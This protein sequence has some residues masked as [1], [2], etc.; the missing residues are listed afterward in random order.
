MSDQRSETKYEAKSAVAIFGAPVSW[1]A[2]F[3]A[4]IG[5]LSI[6]PMAFYPE[7]GGFMSAG[8]GIFAPISGMLLGPWAGFVAGT[9]GGVI[10]M[11][12]SPA[13][14]PLGFLDVMLSGSFM[15]L[16]WG[17]F[18]PKY[19]KWLLVLMPVNFLLYYFVPYY[20]PG[21]SLGLT[22]PVEPAYFIS[23]NCAVIALLVFFIFGKKFMH[24]MESPIVRTHVIGMIGIQFLACS[25]WNWPWV[26]PYSL[27][28]KLPLE[29]TY[30][31]TNLT[32]IN[33]IAPVVGACTAIGYFLLKAMRKG[34][35]RVVPDSWLDG[36]NFQIPI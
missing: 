24:M 21:N 30:V 2:L 19:Y 4:L 11:M 12:I 29:P 28:F 36:Y 33:P 18:I 27:L 26:W 16:A 13:A 32:W 8:M 34:N 1:V 3:G 22:E 5:A 15:P 17:L 10:G 9:I 25:L 35:L 20:F 14:Y 6:I 23:R 7:G 31:T